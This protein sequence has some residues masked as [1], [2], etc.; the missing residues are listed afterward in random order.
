MNTDHNTN[1]EET[2]KTDTSATTMANTE[3]EGFVNHYNHTHKVKLQTVIGV[4][5]LAVVLVTFALF[6][7]I[8]GQSP[9]SRA[10]DALGF[11]RQSMGLDLI[12]SGGIQ[13]GYLNDLRSGQNCTAPGQSLAQD[14]RV[15]QTE[16]TAKTTITPIDSKYSDDL[17]L[18]VFFA[19]NL[20]AD[21]KAVFANLKVEGQVSEKLIEQEKANSSEKYALKFDASNITTTESSFVR[22]DRFAIESPEL[23]SDNSLKDWY[24]G[25]IT[26][27][28]QEGVNYVNE[29]NN[30]VENADEI[31]TFNTNEILSDDTLAEIA[32]QG[33][34]GLGEIDV[35]RT[36][37]ITIN[38]TDIRVR[39]VRV[40]FDLDNALKSTERSQDLAVKLANDSKLE[41][42]VL[43]QFEPVDSIL[44][45]VEKMS[46]PSTEFN[47]DE[48]GNL[49]EESTE[50]KPEFRISREMYEEQVK[51]MFEMARDEASKPSTTSEEEMQ[52]D[53]DEMKEYVD[54][55][56][57]ANVYFDVATSNLLTY[58]TVLEFKLKDKAFE[59]MEDAPEY[60][61]ELLRSGIRIT[62]VSTYNTS[63]EISIPTEFKDFDSFQNDAKIDDS[64]LENAP[65]PLDFLFP[66][67]MEADNVEFEE[68]SDLEPFEFDQL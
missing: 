42:Y 33:C 49:T 26:Y 9:I 10:L 14:I 64:L 6:I 17:N 57:Y 31:T 60:T 47:Y 20:N 68:R 65:N 37:T 46:F 67:T 13:K 56:I 66:A 5:L 7:P 40:N 41:A 58:N 53:L 59:N 19:G 27:P 2:V 24:K 28:T 43:A 21:Q 62:S 29:V 22:L 50:T 11:H 55:Q 16:G 8:Q 45:S 32:K 35:Q 15:L 30:I 63:T 3:K 18:D 36:E 4:G 52:K 34:E 44:E 51:S 38:E 54:L 25:D 1:P 23:N 48:D 12:T 61:K 39:P